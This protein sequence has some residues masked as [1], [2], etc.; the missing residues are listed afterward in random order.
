MNCDDDW[1]AFR[2]VVAAQRDVIRDEDGGCVV[3]IGQLLEELS[4]KLGGRFVVSSDMHRLVDLIEEL[5]ADPHVDQVPHT[6]CIEFAWNEP[7]AEGQA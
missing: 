5:W 1:V 3:S 4:D 7:G 6:G 2:D